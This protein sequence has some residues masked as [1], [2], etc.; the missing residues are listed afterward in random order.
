MLMCAIVTKS[1][2]R[3]SSKVRW[4]VDRDVV[5]PVGE[6]S[7]AALVG[8]VRDRERGQDISTG[9]HL[10]HDRAQPAPARDQ[11]ERRRH[12]RLADATLAGHDDERS[13][14]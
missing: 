5:Q 10:H 12:R 1:L 13:A 9:R 14:E 11:A 2:D 8:R 3:Y 4:G 7:L 6:G